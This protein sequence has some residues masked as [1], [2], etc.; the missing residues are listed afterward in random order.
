MEW[1]SRYAYGRC[2][3]EEVELAPG[4]LEA[5]SKVSRGDLRRAITSL[6]S[7]VRLKASYTAQSERTSHESLKRK[8]GYVFIGIHFPAAVASD[9]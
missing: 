4:A 5:L 7:A 3:D 2:A 9:C 1:S 8:A 6:Q